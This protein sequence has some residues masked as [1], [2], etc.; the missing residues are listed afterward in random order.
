M[1][2]WEVKYQKNFESQKRPEFF[3]VP[4]KGRPSMVSNELV[5]ETKAILH[6]LRINGQANILKTII[7]I[8]NGVL[9][10]RCP[11]K[12]NKNCKSVTLTRIWVQGYGVRIWAQDMVS[13]L[14]KK[15]WETGRSSIKRTLKVRKDQNFLQYLEKDVPQ[16]WVMS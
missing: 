12:F 1:R 2:D 16:W 15:L 8:G 13:A 5:T 6:N 11:K 14:N 10:L 7:A 9:S 3:T 4:W